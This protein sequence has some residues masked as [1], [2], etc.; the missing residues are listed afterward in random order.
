MIFPSTYFGPIAYY[1]ALLSSQNQPVIIDVHEHFVKQTYRNRMRIY[2][3]NGPLDLIIPVCHVG[4]KMNMKDV[5]ID[6][7][8][9]WAQ[10]HWRTMCSAYKKAAYFEYYEPYF[11][12]FYQTIPEK[13]VDLNQ[14]SMNLVFKLLKKEVLLEFSTTYQLPVNEQDWRIQIDPH[15]QHMISI[16]PYG[17]VFQ[18]K[19]GFITNLS[20]LDLIFN[21]GG[22]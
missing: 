7:S 11:E 1:Q 4:G 10:K 3:A 22:V 5:Y 6:T 20:I 16:K 21:K 13:L 15:H 17:Q 19:Q 9:R 2:T 8:E 14:N 18:E 12:T